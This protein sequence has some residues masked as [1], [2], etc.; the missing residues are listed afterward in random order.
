MPINKIVNSFEEAIADI[1]DGATIMVGGFGTVVSMPSC[2]L[3][4][5]AKKGVKNITTVSNSTGFGP[6]VWALQGAKFPEDMDILV[7]NGLIKKAIV[8]APVSAMYVNNFEKLLREGKVEIEMVPQGTLAERIRAAKAG[9]GGVYVPTGVG[10][11]I[12]EGKEKKV[13]DGREYILELP[14]RADFALIHAYKGDRYGNLVYRG[15][16][17]TFNPTMAGAAKVTIAEVDEIVEPGELDPE[18]IVTP[19]VYVDRVVARPKEAAPRGPIV[20][21]QAKESYKRYKAEMKKAQQKRG[22]KR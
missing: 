21:V 11:V 16:S 17:R 9:L 5:L 20:D 3:V 7:R 1:E 8:S 22:G 6:D 12:E 13:I 10:T 2:L 18:A 19:G 15:T 14:I 4:A